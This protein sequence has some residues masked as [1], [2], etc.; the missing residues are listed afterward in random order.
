MTTPAVGIIDAPVLNSPT[1]QA[2]PTAKDGAICGEPASLR[3]DAVRCPTCVPADE[4][5]VIDVCAWCFQ[6]A[7]DGVIRHRPCGH[8][9]PRDLVWVLDP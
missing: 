6:V 3:V 5:R 7:G 4:A 2:Y 8:A 1:C 9:S